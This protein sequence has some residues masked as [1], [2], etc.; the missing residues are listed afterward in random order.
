MSEPTASE[1]V[2]TLLTQTQSLIVIAIQF[3]LGLALGYISVKVL[4][5]IIAFIAILA[6]GTFLSFWSLGI[7]PADVMEKLKLSIEAIKGLALVLGLMTIGPVSLGFLV[8]I[9]I[10]LM[11]R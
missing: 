3:F 6:L 9:V 1:I 4:K 5:Y 2:S 7:T 11:K 10:G 8:G